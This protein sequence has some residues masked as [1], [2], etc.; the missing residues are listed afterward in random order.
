MRI[1]N[2]EIL[3]GQPIL[4]IRAVVRDAMME[5]LKSVDKDYIEERV[6]TLLKQPKSIAKQIINQLVSEDYLV[7]QKVKYGDI[8]QYEI[9]ETEKGRRFGIA[10]ADPP[11]SRE[12]ATQLLNELLERVKQVNATK[13]LIY[14][15]K[16]VKVF[17]SYLSTKDLLGDIDVA[18]KLVRKFDGDKFMEE[19]KK[20]THLAIQKGRTFSNYVEETY[21][22]YREVMLLLKT[23]KKGLSLHDEDADE[24]VRKTEC[25]V[26]YE[27]KVKK[28]QQRANT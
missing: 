8:I 7:L 28:T 24:V 20:R 18:V 2:R 4:K 12:K 15:V 23:K 9:T 25:K 22:P 19:N 17:G 27:F 21:W 6:A 13:E 14:Y 5:R 1:S 10:S 26:V 16:T 3:F 11:I